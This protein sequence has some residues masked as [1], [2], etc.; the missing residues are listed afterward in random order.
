MLYRTLRNVRDIQAEQEDSKFK[1]NPVW[2]SKTMIQNPKGSIVEG[3]SSRWKVL[4][5]IPALQ[6]K[7]WRIVDDIGEVRM[8]LWK[9]EAYVKF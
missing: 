7:E 8:M 4:G 1:T 6:G 9:K 3:Y 2:Y 5:S